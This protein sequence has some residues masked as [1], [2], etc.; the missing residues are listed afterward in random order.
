MAINGIDKSNEKLRVLAKELVV[1]GRQ[2]AA[3]QA[4]KIAD[5]TTTATS[6]SL[7]TPNGAITVADATTPSVTELLEF[8]MELN[9]KVNA[10]IDALEGAGISASA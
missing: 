7:P 1:N 4:A 6:G 3:A 9:A 2:V 5:I 8:C 10:I